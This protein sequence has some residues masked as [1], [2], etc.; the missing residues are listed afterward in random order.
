MGTVQ[1]LVAAPRAVIASLRP[2][3]PEPPVRDEDEDGDDG[4]MTAMAGEMA[5]ALDADGVLVAWHGGADAPTVLYADGACLPASA[6]E[7]LMHE[8]AALAARRGE[9]DG[10]WRTL[11]GDDAGLLTATVAAPGGQ[12][13]I[14]ALFRRVGDTTRLRARDAAGRV[15]P[16]L[17]P[18][19]RLWALRRRA[20]ARLRGMTAAVNQSDVGV[21]LLDDHGRVTFANAAAEALLAEGDGCRRT[22]GMP[23]GAR[24][25]DTMRLQAAVEHILSAH[26]SVHGGPSPV[27]LAATPSPVVALTRRDRRPLLAAVVPGDASGDSAAIVYLFDPEQNLRPLLE[28]ACKLYGLSPVETKLTCHLADGLSLAVA[29]ERMH[30]REQTARSYLKQIFLK[31]DTNRQAELVWLMLKSSVRVGPGCRTSFV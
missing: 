12:L 8:S 19:V 21:L 15:L 20:A 13:T 5:R 27:A 7:S 31:T 24:L 29:A 26:A 9:P 23:S 17:R 16:V 1:R 4:A 10:R 22:G 11:D 2:R 18:F 28:P 3:T 30:V 14:T 25:A 6:E